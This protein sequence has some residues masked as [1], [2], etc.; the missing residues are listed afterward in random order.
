MG[1]ESMLQEILW[2]T[3]IGWWKVDMAR[4]VLLLSDYLCKTIGTEESEIGY[5]RFLQSVGEPFR[6]SLKSLMSTDASLFSA[7]QIFSLCGPRGEVWF[8]WKVLRRETA[9]DKGLVVSGYAQ[10]IS[11][12]EALP[13]DLCSIERMNTLLYR[14]NNISHTLLSFLHIGS[15]DEAINKVLT[16]V[17]KIFR[18]SRTYI[19]EFDWDNR[20]HICTYEVTDK[21]VESGRDR[22]DRLS[23]DET[24]W[25]VEQLEKRSP[26]ALSCLDDLPSRAGNEHD[27]LAAQNIGSLFV[28]PMTFRDKL[29]GYAG[30]DVIGE[31]R[32][33]QNEDYQWFA[34]LVNIINIC[35]ELQRSKREAQIERDY[36]QNLYR[37]MPL[38]YVRFRMIYDKTGT[39]VDY[40]VLDSNY[41]AEKI[42]GKSQADYVGRLAS[43]LEIEDMPEHLKV[44]AKVLQVEQHV[45][46]EVRLL[47]SGRYVHVVMYSTTPEEVICLL[48]D[49]TEMY[50][51]HEA[52][53]RSEKLLRNISVH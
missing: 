8:H 42:I 4:R 15:I 5:D 14:L 53:D 40:K 30:I 41:A 12:R 11:E 47:A 26:I 45:E 51:T 25:W 44:F 18:G 31:H 7:E 37:Y 46:K 24:S 38:G 34:S 17:L 2:D 48:S 19:A 27:I 32:D 29:W 6:A 39:P 13:V 21:G 28:L 50:E 35:I 10:E 3:K 49:M 22:F 16:D 9:A 23:M 43:E 52:L 36:L 20:R 33:W 1:S